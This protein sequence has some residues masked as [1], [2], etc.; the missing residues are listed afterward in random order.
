MAYTLCGIRAAGHHLLDVL[1]AE[2]AVNYSRFYNLDRGCDVALAAALWGHVERT[3]NESGYEGPGDYSL[4]EY[5][6]ILVEEGAWQLEDLGVVSIVFQQTPL[7]DGEPDFRITLTERGEEFLSEGRPLGFHRYGSRT[8]ATEASEWLV[9]FLDGGGP[10]QTL[11]LREVMK[12]GASD[13]DVSVTDEDGN[14]YGPETRSYAWA[15]EVSMW[16]H[17]RCG[18][19]EPVFETPDQRRAWEAFFAENQYLFPRPELA[20]PHPLWDVPFR[21]TAKDTEAVQHVGWIGGE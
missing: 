19:I 16:H 2:K 4:V 21:L 1:A 18:N 13:G 9:A 14:R 11:T 8:R 20:E 17:T 3:G 5:C 6:H 10:G 15:F 7:A 12:F